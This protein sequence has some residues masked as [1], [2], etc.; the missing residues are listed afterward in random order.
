MDLAPFA[1]AS[2]MEREL[3][4]ISHAMTDS[5]HSKRS[6]CLTDGNGTSCTIKLE[7]IVG[8]VNGVSLKIGTVVVVQI[9]GRSGHNNP[10][11]H[12]PDANSNAS[13]EWS[14][15]PDFL[16]NKWEGILLQIIT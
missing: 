3:F 5:L 4:P 11:L 13:R 2:A 15:F 9:H 6:I 7:N 16:V 8:R 14:P 10:H 12:I 1:R